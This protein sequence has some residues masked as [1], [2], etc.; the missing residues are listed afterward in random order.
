LNF[1]YHQED[2]VA[3]DEENI[4]PPLPEMVQIFHSTQDIVQQLYKITLIIRRPVKQS[5]KDKAASIDVSHYVEFDKEHVQARFPCAQPELR[6]RLAKAITRRRQLLLYQERHHEAL[7]EMARKT[8]GLDHASE[9][10]AVTYPQTSDDATS[11]HQPQYDEDNSYH[12]YTAGQE[13]ESRYALSTEAT[14]FVAPER[15]Q[16]IRTD[17]QE[18]IFSGTASS[19]ASTASGK[20]EIAIPRCPEDLSQN[21][22]V[23]F[24]CPLCFY[25]TEVQTNHQWR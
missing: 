2:N 8:D 25:M 18:S 9:D 11:R 12:D 13:A 24:E 19:Y 22:P 3:Y 6:D 21:K 1:E 17:D 20:D 10:T 14:T 5:S 23:V 16:N 7:A 4:V 15:R